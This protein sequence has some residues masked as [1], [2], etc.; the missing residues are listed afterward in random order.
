MTT[1]F[2]IFQPLLKSLK[3]FVR[4]YPSENFFH[5]SLDVPLPSM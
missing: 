1:N 4:I 5:H 2:L 3:T